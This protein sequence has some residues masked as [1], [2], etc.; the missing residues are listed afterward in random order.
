MIRSGLLALTL[1]ALATDAASADDASAPG[2]LPPL[3]TDRPTKSTAPCTA[4]LGHLQLESDIVNVT[5]DHSGGADSTTVLYTNPTVKWGVSPTADVELNIA[6][7]ETV[8]SRDRRTGVTTRQTGAGDLYGRFKLELVGANGG[9]ASFGLSPFVK[10]PTA[11][12]GIGNGAVEEG[13][14]APISL[15]LPLNWSLTI[16]PELDD[17]K[18]AEN[19]GR[20]V[21][22][23]GLMSFSYPATKTLTVSIELWGDV[24]NDPGGSV[25]QASA[26]L[27]LAWIPADHPNLQWDGGVNLGLNPDT[28]VA[29]AYIGVS[30]RF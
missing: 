4:P 30:R 17:L 15:S 23:A 29:Q 10:I 24:N 6:P 12:G 5:L 2:A 9:N 26:D 21:N 20:H 19:Q 3:C 8:I 22:A 27:G 14:I 13:L 25:R 28:P 7:V 18:N 1:A 11:G 16:D